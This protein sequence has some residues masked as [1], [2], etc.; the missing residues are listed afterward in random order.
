MSHNTHSH[1]AAS[2]PAKENEGELVRLADFE[3]LIDW[4]VDY[5]SRRHSL[6]EDEPYADEGRARDD[7]AA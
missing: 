4:A 6:Y 2:R 5:W 7:E 1:E 3:A